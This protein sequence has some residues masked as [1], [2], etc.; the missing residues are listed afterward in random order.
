MQGRSYVDS[1]TMFSGSGAG[2]WARNGHPVRMTQVQMI[3]DGSQ[4]LRVIVINPLNRTLSADLFALR[5]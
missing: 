5:D 3:S 1:N 4:N 2:R